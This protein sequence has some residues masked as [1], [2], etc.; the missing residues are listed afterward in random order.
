M[1]GF[2]TNFFTRHPVLKLA[3]KTH[4]QQTWST[5][6]DAFKRA[7][8]LVFD[9]KLNGVEYFPDF[10][11]SEGDLVAPREV[12][13][14]R[15]GWQ[16]TIRW[17][18]PRRNYPRCDRDHMLAVGYFHE[19]RPDAPQIVLTPFTRGDRVAIIDLPDNAHPLT[20]GVHLYPFFIERYYQ[21][22]SKSRH[23][24]CEGEREEI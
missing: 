4:G 22:F 5:S 11:F 12:R 18:V 8:Y 3:W 7:N 14:T 16:F 10:L 21:A 17:D 13:V 1:T 24:W 20:E 2:T 9:P 6:L 19:S 23:A 15:D